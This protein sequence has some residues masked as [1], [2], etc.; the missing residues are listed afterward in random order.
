MHIKFFRYAPQRFNFVPRKGW[1][2]DVKFISTVKFITKEEDPQSLIDNNKFYLCILIAT[3]SCVGNIFDTY[4]VHHVVHV[5]F[6]TSFI[7]SIQEMSWCGCNRLEINETVDTY[8][9]ILSIDDF[10]YLNERLYE[11]NQMVQ[12]LY[13]E[14]SNMKK[15]EFSNETIYWNSLQYCC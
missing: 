10:V 6:P 9:L 4:N 3:T 13:T 11:E 12:L 14:P 8:S 1:M 2:C 7:N 15:T 5:G